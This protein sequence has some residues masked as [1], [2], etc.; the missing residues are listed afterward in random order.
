VLHLGHY[1]NFVSG[2]FSDM[3]VKVRLFG[4]HSRHGEGE[5]VDDSI[6][7]AQI[8]EVSQKQDRTNCHH[9]QDKPQANF[10]AAGLHDLPSQWEPS[11]SC[12]SNKERRRNLN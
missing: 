11:R 8:P 9:T 2:R 1:N 5:I 12:R 4:L 6:L 7:I 10:D 3:F